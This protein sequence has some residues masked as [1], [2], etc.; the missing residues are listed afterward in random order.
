MGFRLYGARLASNTKP[1]STVTA[2]ALFTWK[3]RDQNMDE[4]YHLEED[5]PNPL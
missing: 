1:P 4:D 2:S 5:F 3:R